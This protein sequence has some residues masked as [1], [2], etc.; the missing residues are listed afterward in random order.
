MPT[1]VN[2]EAATA[3]ASTTGAPVSGK[4]F[5]VALA[6]SP[7]T[8]K[9]TL[10]NALTGLRAQTANFP[11]TTVERKRGWL[12]IDGQRFELIDLPGVYSLRTATAEERVACDILL[13]NKPGQVPPDAVVVIANA[14]N[15]ERSLFLIS[16]LLEHD[17]PVVVALNM[18]DV[19][20]SHGI[21]VDAQA[22]SQD[23]G[24]PVV[25]MVARGG[26]GIEDLKQELKKLSV[27]RPHDDGIEFLPAQR[28]CEACGTCPFQSRYTWSDQVAAHCV[29]APRVARGRKTEKI[30]RF[31]THPVV[32][33][34]AFLTVMMTVF[35]LIFA[36][37]TVPMDMIDALFGGL[38]GW[39]AGL[40]PAGD[41]QSLLVDGI[42]GGV[43]GILVFL[44]QICILF[45]FLAVLE[46][47]GYLAR[48]AFVMDRLMR[49]I[50]LP[51]TA[52]VP[53]LSAH[54]CAIPAIMA[55]RVIRDP[56]D[57]LVTILVAPLMTC[58]A[59][60]PVYAMVTALLFP[61]DPIRA[62][63]VF[64]GAYALGLV[65]ALV[66]AWVFKKTILPGE[67]KPLVL[68]L[69]GYR[70]PSLR[71]AVIQTI[72]RAKVFVKQAGTI[73]LM[74]SVILWALA[75]YPKSVTPPEAVQLAAQS[76]VL[77]AEGA[78][79]EANILSARASS[80]ASRHALSQS[81]AGRIGKLIE[82][83]VR[84]LGFDWQIGIGIVSSFA[85][86]EVIVSTLAI[87]YGLGEDTVDDDPA[88]LHET[89]R[90]AH[91]EDG[92]PV[93][94]VA[95]SISL[96]VFYVLAMQCLPTQ[97]ITKRETNSWKWPIFQLVY[98]TLLAYGASFVAYRL[99]LL[100]TG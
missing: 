35:Y 18:V 79:D 63:L 51:G 47:S 43:G 84:P 65:A 46:D 11:G 54:A 48:A 49:R 8:G 19:A 99:T 74:I 67:S 75:T 97:A 2:Q 77:A 62:A 23:L 94:T 25:P 71:T 57:R 21:H 31:L 70:I 27:P 64:T 100:F 58:S 72:D 1:A 34:G 61:A 30:D 22:L 38:G 24:C 95:T 13:G 82:P 76:E 96:L 42:I 17:L 10:F 69:P 52:F 14:D 36:V 37:A 55:S 20:E 91:H 93:F 98:M 32:G 33:V 90:R 40:V 83:V 59:R 39:V 4:S 78:T 41:F 88:S 89:M 92:S 68:E 26:R 73:I 85:A 44:P 6:G 53:L 29:Q 12:S 45:F 87:V 9:T 16:Q 5:L 15:I 28:S 3:G 86:R 81:F 80:L 60:I 50:G 7:N 56:R 66:M